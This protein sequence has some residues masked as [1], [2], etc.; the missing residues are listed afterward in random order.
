MPTPIQQRY[1]YPKGRVEYSSRKGGALW[2]MYGSDG[3]EDT[4][5][6][7]LHVYLSP[8]RAANQ[9][10][11]LSQHE[12]RHHSASVASN[13]R[14]RGPKTK[15][16]VG[17]G[18]SSRA[19]FGP[20]A[21][22][23]APTTIVSYSSAS[24]TVGSPP[25]LSPLSM[26]TP[27]TPQTNSHGQFQ[28]LSSH[29]APPEIRM[30]SSSRH[31]NTSHRQ[32]GRPVKPAP[33]HQP[34]GPPHR[35][36]NAAAFVTPS[37]D[38]MH[39]PHPPSGAYPRHRRPS[40]ATPPRVTL[41]PQKNPF[42]NRP[43]HVSQQGRRNSNH[44]HHSGQDFS[45]PAFLDDPHADPFWDDVGG[46][47]PFDGALADGTG[48][49]HSPV[50][51]HDMDD[52]RPWWPVETSNGYPSQQPRHDVAHQTHW[53]APPMSAAPSMS[54]HPYESKHRRHPSSNASMLFVIGATADHHGPSPATDAA[55]KVGQKA[56]LQ[57]LVETKKSLTQCIERSPEAE[58][59]SMLSLVIGW[60]SQ[61]ARDPLSTE[62]SE[63]AH[64]AAPA[65]LSPPRVWTPRTEGSNVHDSAA[66]MPGLEAASPTNMVAEILTANSFHETSS[67]CD[68]AGRSGDLIAARPVNLP[69]DT[70]LEA[71]SDGSSPSSFSSTPPTT[72][73]SPDA[74]VRIKLEDDEPERGGIC[75]RHHPDLTVVPSKVATV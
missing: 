68:A 70:H 28:L 35:D 47:D 40:H 42:R 11:Q 48:A 50:S 12:L 67:E 74:R 37:R 16:V 56:L 73:I 71:P 72:P 10:I 9:G 44:V 59:A 5:F 25:S 3:K 49:S 65:A 34:S 33:P 1:C 30:S 41:D 2:T 66:P 61:L 31:E 63:P 27:S 24:A 18:V 57:K 58:Q 14:M 4:E 13:K 43:L 20:G 46:I 60:A 26:Y 8:K 75:A 21:R 36:R 19:A 17:S 6:R 69:E 62:D 29:R 23:P 54:R 53:F 64:N 32:Y 52:A 15:D 7:L 55:P 51:S 22:G 45:R 39:Q 38:A